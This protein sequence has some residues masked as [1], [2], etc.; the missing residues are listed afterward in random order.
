MLKWLR[1]MLDNIKEEWKLFRD[2]VYVS[3]LGNLKGLKDNPR[4]ATRKDDGYYI[5]DYYKNKKRYMVRLHRAVAE[6]FIPNPNNL[7]CINHKDGD[8]SNNSVTNLEW[9]S[10]SENIKHAYNTGLH[11][12][13]IKDRRSNPRSKLTPEQVNDILTIYKDK[14][15]AELGRMYGVTKECIYYI[16]NKL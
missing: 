10:Y 12:S 9:C 11:K 6:C 4:K 14:T 5:F 15:G 8:K 7:P 1:G 16:R 13:Y 2:S 3:N